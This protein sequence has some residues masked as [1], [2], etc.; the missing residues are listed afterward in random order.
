MQSRGGLRRTPTLS[1]VTHLVS[2]SA[3]FLLR[4]IFGFK[5]RLRIYL[6]TSDCSM[7]P[8]DKLPKHSQLH[9]LHLLNVEIT[10]LISQNECK[11]HIRHICNDYIIT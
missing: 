10:M 2:Q 7:D 6:G 5:Q 9:F 4:D 8:S 11:N 1:R 3:T